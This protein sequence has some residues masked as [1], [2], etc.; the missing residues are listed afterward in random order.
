MMGKFSKAAA[1]LALVG[2]VAMDPLSA[3]I[4]PG[5][6]LDGQWGT[7]PQG[8]RGA[9]LTSIV[10]SDG[11]VS[12]FGLTFGYNENGESQWLVLQFDMLEHQ[13][14]ATANVLLLDGGT[15]GFPIVT[16]SISTIGT[17]D[18]TLNTCGDLD[19]SVD[20]TSAAS[21]FADFDWSLTPLSNAANVGLGTNP[22][23]VYTEAFQ[24]CPAFAAPAVGLERACILNGVI[25][26]QDIT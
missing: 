7:V 20:I 13:F 25:R 2:A 3:A 4:K 23:C 11:S 19:L 21:G 26:N 6:W 5:V 24:G 14:Q 8:N 17:A 16:P 18:L 10:N 1:G 15:S 22:Q 9:T 12:V